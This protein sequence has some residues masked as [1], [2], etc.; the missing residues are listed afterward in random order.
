[1]SELTYHIPP[2]VDDVARGAEAVTAIVEPSFSQPIERRSRRPRGRKLEGTELL[3]RYEVEAEI[4]HG[5]MATVYRGRHKTIDKPVAIKVLD[6]AIEGLPDAVERFLQEAR[7]TSRV[8]HENVVE[9]NDFGVTAD[10]V[11]FSVMELLQG[12]TLGDLVDAEGPLPPARACA[13]MLQICSALQAAHTHGIIHRDLKPD[14]CFRTPRTSNP[15]FIK[16]L[17]FG[18]AR[19]TP[20]ASHTVRAAA[21]A[22]TEVGCIVGTPDYMAPEQARAEP[23]DHRVDV[24]AA[25]GL[26]FEL[27]TGRKPYEGS[28][29]AEQLAA[30]LHSPVPDPGALVP[31]LCP[32]LR[33][34]VR[35]AM[36]KDADDRHPSMAALAQDIVHAQRQQTKWGG[37]LGRVLE[38]VAAVATASA[39]VLGYWSLREEP[40]ALASVSLTELASPRVALAM[41]PSERAPIVRVPVEPVPAEIAPSPEEPSI[42]AEVVSTRLR[43]TP[44]ATPH[45]PHARARRAAIAEAPREVELPTADGGDAALDDPP[46]AIDDEPVEEAPREPADEHVAA[47]A[48]A[49]ADPA[50][51]T[52]PRDKGTDLKDPFAD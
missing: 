11:V 40:P 19:I 30:H 36:A 10:G 44:D 16:V 48:E 25:G 49:P 26:F 33:D 22:R 24:Y 27:L 52:R 46:P 42:L 23:F 4:G 31:A 3:A 17:D 2:L 45:K 12:E 14:N 13:I 37:P 47:P 35:K 6:G 18:I 1:M 7:V 9:V 8:I 32:A 21:R 41:Q 50:P 28:C 39:L 20:E 34:V 51:P 43:D 29:A 5:G 38:R 15:D